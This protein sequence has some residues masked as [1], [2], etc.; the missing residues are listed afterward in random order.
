LDT[1]YHC[2]RINSIKNLKL[3]ARGSKTNFIV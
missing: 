3:S 2:S 1:D